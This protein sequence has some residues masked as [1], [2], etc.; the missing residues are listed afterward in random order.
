MLLRE[1][2]DDPGSASLLRDLADREALRV[3]RQMIHRLRRQLGPRLASRVGQAARLPTEPFTCLR[4]AVLGFPRAQLDAWVHQIMVNGPRWRWRLRDDLDRYLDQG[5][6]LARREPPPSMELLALLMHVRAWRSLGG[7][8]AVTGEDGPVMATFLD[9]QTRHLAVRV[10]HRLRVRRGSIDIVSTVRAR[11][12]QTD[13][14]RTELLA[15]LALATAH[16]P[17]GR[18]R[19]WPFGRVRSAA[20][21][22]LPAAR[23]LGRLV[24]QSGD[25]ARWM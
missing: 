12:R 25:A 4:R 10:E 7:L 8:L 19:R 5:V 2:F 24:G 9:E 17:Q 16:D 18:T 21:R 23:L 3:R 6:I 22:W 1:A 13:A 20:L 11:D 14:D 15:G